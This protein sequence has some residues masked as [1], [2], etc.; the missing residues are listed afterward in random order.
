[1][2][3]GGFRLPVLRQKIFGAVR[4][5]R[6]FLMPGSAGAESST[7]GARANPSAGISSDRDGGERSQ[8]LQRAE[9]KIAKQREQIRKQRQELKELR[10]KVSEGA[11][12]TRDKSIRPENVVWILGSPRTGSTWLAS[13]MEEFEG[14]TVWREPYVGQLFGRFYYDWVGEKHFETKHLILGRRSRESWSRSIRNFIL[15]E[16]TVRFPAVSGEEY[17]VVREPNGSIGAPLLMEAL[18]ESRM[19]FLV[20][21]PRDIVA[22]RLDATRKGSWLYERR[23]EQGGGR[24][25]M[26]D[27]QTDAFVESTARQ[28]LENMGN[29]KEAYEAHNGPKVLVKYEELRVDA[30]GTMRRIYSALGMETDDDELARAVEKHAWENV[31]EEDKGEGKFHRKATPGGWREDLTE[32]QVEAVERITSPLLKEFYP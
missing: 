15:A 25:A 17:L 30:L 10:A 2:Q 5:L 26:F 16:A 18:P 8:R 1:M 7:A 20:R 13:M 19:I 4:S 24:T 14:H 29:T 27:M 32:E 22:S 28:C 12:G 9:Q 11:R 31:P 23:V 3:D 6:A 21:D